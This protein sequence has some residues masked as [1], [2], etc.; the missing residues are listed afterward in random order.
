MSSNAKIA[1]IILNW[2]GKKDTLECLASIKKMED[3]PS[4]ITIVVDNGSTDDSA[5][6][7][8]QAHPEIT[9]LQTGQNLGFSG[10]NNV[11]IQYALE[12]GADYLFL[13]NNDT[14]VDPSIL[15]HFKE[16]FQKDPSI[17]ILGA[18]IYLFHSK[19]TFDHFGGSWNQKK[20]EFDF[21]GWRQIED[22]KSFEEMHPI[23]Y[24]CGAA[25]MIKKEVFARIGLLE[26]RFFL[27]WEDADFC[28]R[29]RNAG[30]KVM[31]CPK[32][33]IWHKVHASFVGGKIHSTYFNARNRLLWIERHCSF[34]P[35]CFLF[36]RLFLNALNLYKLKFLKK[37]QLK[38]LQF[39]RPE[40]DLKK[41]K[42]RVLRYEAT[43]CGIKDYLLR[44]F[45]QGP[46]WIYQRK[47]LH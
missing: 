40:E 41:R 8:L 16:G 20:A 27:M 18:K 13:L 9:L 11:G 46:E 43:L 35:K 34:W 19:D 4:F 38:L 3:N 42:E 47:K 21:I 6:A 28:F 7:I 31:T 37:G 32:A 1:I 23:D 24:V 5:A 33:I 44:N 14:A 39:L 15:K 12:Q 36:T 10:G 30:F 25:M 22:K 2:N 45:G 26:P 17:G 29:A